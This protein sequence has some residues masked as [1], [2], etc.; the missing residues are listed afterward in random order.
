[1]GQTSWELDVP[2]SLCWDVAAGAEGQFSAGSTLV[3]LAGW[4][5][6]ST[7]DRKDR[8]SRGKA[9]EQRCIFQCLK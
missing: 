9:E 5:G 7:E 8:T 2:E 4:E 1:M 3:L 6:T